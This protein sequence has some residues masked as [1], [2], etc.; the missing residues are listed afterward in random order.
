MS[1]NQSPEPHPPWVEYPDEEPFWGGWR[2]GS[3]EFW[4][5][6]TWFPYWRKLTQNQRLAYLERWH[7]PDNWR[8]H[9]STFWLDME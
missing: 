4:L 5:H 6:Y 8:E 7:V 1:T 2:Q 3:G 9:I